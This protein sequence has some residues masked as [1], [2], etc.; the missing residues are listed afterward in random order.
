MV[1]DE[2]QDYMDGPDNHGIYDV[3]TI[4]NLRTAHCP[5]TRLPAG[6]VFERLPG[7]K[8]FRPVKDWSP[9]ED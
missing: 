1:G 7:T 6:S 2:D 4:A 8:G 5:A 9:P 3:N